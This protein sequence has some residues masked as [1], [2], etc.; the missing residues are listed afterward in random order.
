MSFFSKFFQS[1][2]CRIGT[3]TLSHSMVDLMSG[4]LPGVLPVALV[5]F[6]MDLST[7]VII[8]SCMGIG[9]NVM[10]IPV[11]QLGKNSQSPRYIFLGL[12]MSSLILTLGLLPR[13]TPVICLCLLMLLVGF[14]I[15]ITHPNGLRAAQNIPG[16]SPTVSTP[17]FM[18]GGF[19][20]ASVGPWL[21]GTLAEHFGLK[22]LL[23]LFPVFLLLLVFLYLGKFLLALD[24][25]AKNKTDSAEKQVSLWSF[26]SLFAIAL[27][28]NTGSATLQNLLP[29]LLHEQGYSLQIGGLH[30]MVFGFGSAAGSVLLG[31]LVKKYKPQW[32]LAGGLLTGTLAMI[33]YMYLLPS[34]SLILI[35]LAGFLAT[36]GY[37][38]LVALSRQAPGKYGISAR[39]GLIVGGTWGGAGVAFLGI[40]QLAAKFGLKPIMN[41]VW[42]CYLAA[43]VIL[44]LTMR[45]K[46]KNI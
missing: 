6:R 30:A 34:A 8:L 17:L 35:L 28:M 2:P 18:T 31:F 20:G 26:N 22:G 39:M 41:T 11:A 42:I 15:A 32:F 9:C 14:G 45:R 24:S 13:T 19:F 7:A 46:Q 12:T 44:L 43:L 5:Y 27:V 21:S 40:G 23:L 10:Q 38:I 3:L 4:L 29:T 16:M 37:P 36:S 33:A 25:S 1:A